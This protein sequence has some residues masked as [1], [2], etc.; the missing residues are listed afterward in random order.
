MTPLKRNLTR[1]FIFFLVLFL[2]ATIFGF[3]YFFKMERSED[4]LNTLY[5]REL[6]QIENGIK[7]SIEK[8]NKTGSYSL[9]FWRK[10][11]DKPDE[12]F[13]Q[14]GEKF[15]DLASS[16]Q[17]LNDIKL[18]S[19][20]F[21]YG[22]C[23]KGKESFSLNIDDFN[24]VEFTKTKCLNDGYK[25]TLRLSASID[26]VLSQGVNRFQTVALVESNG[27]VQSIVNNRAMLTKEP[28]LYLKKISSKVF[29]QN[30]AKLG[31]S[32]S[33]F[34]THFEDITLDRNNYRVYV[35]PIVSRGLS[36]D[37]KE[38]FL[39]GLVNKQLIVTEKLKLPSEVLMWLILALLLFI[40]CTPLLKLR[41]VSATYAIQ[42]GDKSQIIL[43]LIIAVGILSIG[44]SQQLFQ[45][46]LVSVK[47]EQ[48]KNI[49]KSIVNDAKSELVRI[50]TATDPNRADKVGKDNRFEVYD[51]KVPYECK[52]ELGDCSIQ[53]IIDSGWQDNIVNI[54]PIETRTFLETAIYLD[55][56]GKIQVDEL[57]EKPMY[58]SSRLELGKDTDLSH[59]EYF[60]RGKK[61]EFWNF[62]NTKLF[63][64]RIFNIEDG[65]LNSVIAYPVKSAKGKKT[66][67]KKTTD[68]EG[69]STELKVVGA[70][71][72]SLVDRVLPKNFGFAV[73]DS[74]GDV[75][76]HSTDSLSL[77]ENFFTEINQDPLA[78]I[79]NNHRQ[80]E[81]INFDVKYKGAPHKIAVGPLFN[82]DE[83]SPVPWNLVVFFDPSEV[84][85]NNM[86]LVFVAV[87]LY[88]LLIIPSFLVCRYFLVQKFWQ[89]ICYYDVE[90]D[91]RYYTLFT[92][93]AVSMV[94]CV[95]SLMGIVHSLLARLTLWGLACVAMMFVLC[96]LWRLNYSAYF[97]WYRP[98]IIASLMLIPFF[99]LTICVDW[100][101]NYDII[102][103]N[104]QS[105]IVGGITLLAVS[106]FTLYRLQFCNS[107]DK[108]QPLFSPKADTHFRQRTNKQRYRFPNNY[109]AYLASL[110][111]LAAAT[112]ATVIT[113]SAHEYLLERQANFEEDYLRHSFRAKSDDL[114]RYMR[115]ISEKEDIE[116]PFAFPSNYES[117]TAS[118]VLEMVPR[119]KEESTNYKEVDDWNWFIF[120][121][122]HS[123]ST[124][125]LFDLLFN[126]TFDGT[127]FVSHLT[128][129]AKLTLTESKRRSDA[130]HYRADNFMVSALSDRRSRVVILCMFLF[131]LVL[132]VTVRQLIV[133]RLMGEH[134]QNQYRVRTKS[135][136]N[137]YYATSFPN[138]TKLDD[139]SN[140]RS[141]LILNT[142]RALAEV[143]L[144]EIAKNEEIILYQQQV[145]RIMDCLDKFYS[146]EEH[147]E[148]FFF[149][150][151]LRIFLNANKNKRVIVAISA[152]EQ[153]SLDISLRKDALELL[154]EIHKDPKIRLVIVAETAPLYRILTPNAYQQNSNI[155]VGID[156]KTS[157]TKL[158]SEFDKHYAW[159]PVCK[160]RL[161]NP[162]AP[163]ALYDYEVQAWPEMRALKD[164]YDGRL[165]RE[166]E[167]VIEYML[168]HAGPIYRRKWEECTINEKV[169]LWRIANGASINPE[170]TTTIE[171][172]MRRC[173]LYRDKGWSL[174]NESFR[175]FILT[176]E[177]EATMRE[178]LDNTDV[179]VWTVLRVPIFALL[180]VL[181]AVF[182]YS[183]GSSLDT[184]LGIATATLG[185]IPLL[186]KNLSLLRGG[187]VTDIE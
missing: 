109:P 118:F 105:A 41:F 186:I 114:L 82:S 63:L 113:Y 61:N 78:I 140:R 29:S 56:N 45:G 107:E 60:K 162:F 52:P 15:K 103:L 175:Q 77:V 160:K 152:L 94:S 98:K 19:P 24:S 59:R 130:L 10:E 179:G 74:Q 157:W 165:L 151:K 127:D 11:T 156:E 100:R 87:L 141:Q 33:L 184:F 84:H 14:A 25:A 178:W 16:A 145:F 137:D 93:I 117:L 18:H 134:L 177:S 154:Y 38:Y 90:I 28:E 50:I 47:E 106:V 133:R 174:I 149:L 163:K 23:K 48:L 112:P 170:S 67:S 96:S 155:T 49:H 125:K 85:T 3:V 136:K 185:L 32:I 164:K 43:G 6:Q 68:E 181:V 70:R 139:V 119:S 26:M 5:F 146:S 51:I 62:S 158:Y 79:A 39:V 110:V 65:R 21:T 89:D 101:L 30:T 108:G 80:S 120:D 27:L 73:I 168:V 17:E 37:K 116:V 86:I 57:G 144:N 104:W 20:E 180:L 126:S 54:Q 7:R 132:F 75:I 95:I 123:S 46:Y 92:V 58:A 111:F 36:A 35:H 55:G 182:V 161:D 12:F 183:S 153:I 81:V 171:R 169:I 76:Y 166:P 69:D 115:F 99:L 102:L 9:S 4:I 40:A 83:S 128:Y 71:I 131:P 150:K 13:N 1:F 121:S 124:D 142:T 42:R 66:S 72:S 138:L 172:L 44:L 91:T 147:L 167:Q 22:Y 129:E 31:D 2:S 135:E 97:G 173:Y 159:S 143:E 122:D 8:V 34:G 176:A 64:Q 187:T 53:Y 88:L 148:T